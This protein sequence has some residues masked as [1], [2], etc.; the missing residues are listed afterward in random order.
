MDTHL[1][2]QHHFAQGQL[3]FAQQDFAAALEH[4][5]Q[6]ALLMPSLVEAWENIAVCMANQGLTHGEI[7][8]A[9]FPQVSS[10]HHPRLQ[11]KI[12]ALVI[13]TDAERAYQ[14]ALRNMDLELSVKLFSLELDNGAV[15][16][17]E[18]IVFLRNLY[19]SH[20]TLAKKRGFMRIEHLLNSWLVNP[21]VQHCMT[22]ATNKTNRLIEQ[23]SHDPS[24]KIS[25]ND[26]LLIETLGLIHYTY[27][28]YSNAALCFQCLL[29]IVEE[30]ERKIE[31]QKHL[32]TCYSLNGEYEKALVLDP[33][34]STAWERLAPHSPQGFKAQALRLAEQAKAIG[35]TCLPYWPARFVAHRDSEICIA[36]LQ[37]ASICGQDPMV[38]DS[39]FVYA[40]NR[41]NM[42]F[43][44]P[45]LGRSELMPKGI[46]VFSTNSNNHYHL[47]IE[48][49]AR[50]L[51][52]CPHLPFDVPIYI[53][54]ED[55]SRH[56]TLL[57]LLK[58]NI[59]IVGF[60][61]TESLTFESLWVVD[62]SHPA[63]QLPAPANMWDCYLSHA[64]S[65]NRLAKMLLGSVSTPAGSSKADTL[66]YVRRQSGPRSI[67]DPEDQI[68]ALLKGY[69]LQNNLTFVCFDGALSFAEQIRLFSGARI[70][71]GIHGAGLANLIFA[72]ASCA[73]VE[74]PIDHNSNPLFQELSAMFS[75]KHLLCKHTCDYLGQLT[76]NTEL[77]EDIKITLELL[78]SP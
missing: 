59:P 42:R 4:F 61:V 29:G 28:N 25:A 27:G 19:M 12:N 9:I 41:G 14:K 18:A 72:P 2:I 54:T 8:A 63:H 62:I 67:H 20:E 48:F 45:Q 1:Q 51:A 39:D 15:D 16:N 52:A 75:K 24:F 53:A 22:L 23:Q 21:A 68:N 34:N 55:T 46:V 3:C 44:P 7:Q 66:I 35:R 6:C 58:I 78:E 17:D 71:F 43:T 31:Y 5:Q 11:H 77:L 74:I 64:Q 37:N 57:D 65:V 10:E 69:C 73:V 13:N 33:S 70:I 26:V 40:G 76:A 56:R 36:H 30:P 47:L 49:G 32:S 60:S 50:L 38:Y